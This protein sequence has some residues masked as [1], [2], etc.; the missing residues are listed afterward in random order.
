MRLKWKVTFLAVLLVITGALAHADEGSC[1]GAD[2][3]P[4]LILSVD[5][6]RITQVLDSLEDIQGRR[7][8]KTNEETLTSLREIFESRPQK[9]KLE[10]FFQLLYLLQNRIHHHLLPVTVTPPGITELL[11]AAKVFTDPA[12]PARITKVELAKDDADRPPL[13]RVTFDSNEVRFPINQGRGFSTWDQGMCQTVKELVFY[14]GFSFRLRKARNSDNLIVDNFDKVE[15]FGDFGTRKVVS[16]DLNYVD[17]EKVEFIKGTDQ[18]KVKARVARR[19]FHENP[20]SKLFKF[21]GSLIPNTSKQR[22][23][24]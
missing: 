22:I 17:L 8:W 3:P 19:E 9:T 14:P 12:F 15:M 11:L 18:G 21:V 20:H 7:F 2:D 23:D 16:I 24:W 4:P 1:P 13:Y 5:L 6:G 10:Q